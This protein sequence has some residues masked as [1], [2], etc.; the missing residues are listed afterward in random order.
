M[1]NFNKLI[2]EKNAEQSLVAR[3]KKSVG[4]ASIETEI[5][6]IMLVDLKHIIPNVNQPRQNFENDE[7]IQ[8]LA[9]SIKEMGL[10]SP[11]VVNKTGSKYQILIGHRRYYAYQKYIP[12]ETQI[13]CIVWQKEKMSDDERNKIALVENLQRKE[14]NAVEIAETLNKLKSEEN[15]ETIQKLTGYRKS[16]IS[17]Y[18]AC[19]RA[20]KEGIITKEKLI[21]DG[22][23]KTCKNI[24]KIKSSTVELDDFTNK[25]QKKEVLKVVIEDPGNVEHW[26]HAK[27]IWEGHLITITGMINQL[28]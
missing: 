10:Q 27:K 13:K 1:A 20:I 15:T 23:R 16:S 24:R 19:F 26:K 9:E 21:S 18:L 3:N 22:V 28:K 8:D 12:E 7:S 4:S 5:D 25:K 11:I 2:K 17:E 6:K 14:L